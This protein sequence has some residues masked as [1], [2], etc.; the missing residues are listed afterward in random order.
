MSEVTP[1]NNGKVP[2][3]PLPEPQARAVDFQVIS[4]ALKKIQRNKKQRKDLLAKLKMAALK[5][6]DMPTSV[7]AERLVKTLNEVRS[8]P[9]ASSERPE[10]SNS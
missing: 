6:T 8:T 3:A 5:P 4:K 1:K 10:F 2:S 7:E 9:E